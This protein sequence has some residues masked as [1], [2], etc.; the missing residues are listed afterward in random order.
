MIENQKTILDKIQQKIDDNTCEYVQEDFKL[1]LSSHQH[2]LNTLKE[3]DEI[4]LTELSREELHNFYRK[5]FLNFEPIKI[6]FP[7]KGD[8]FEFSFFKFLKAEYL[9][10]YKMKVTME[11]YENEF[12]ENTVLT[13]TMHLYDDKPESTKIV[14]KNESG[15]CALFDFFENNEDD[16]EAFDIF[17]EFYMHMLFLAEEYSEDDEN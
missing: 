9:E 6:F 8:D 1:K 12:V 13:K 4:L 14:W 16:F 2:I 17:Y 15:R 10:N 5:V 3:R 7:S 11:L